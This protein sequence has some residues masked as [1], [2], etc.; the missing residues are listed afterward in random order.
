MKGYLD[1]V[2]NGQKSG[3]DSD[4]A[5]AVEQLSLKAYLKAKLSSQFQS[6]DERRE[7]RINRTSSPAIAGPPPWCPPP[8]AAAGTAARTAPSSPPAR[9]P[10]QT[11]PACYPQTSPGPAIPARSPRG[12][13]HDD[14]VHAAVT[15]SPIH[16]GVEVAPLHIL[17][18]RSGAVEHVVD[19]HVERA[20]PRPGPDVLDR[21]LLDKRD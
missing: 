9:S 18:P 17:R 11:P 16:V 15:Q 8:A 19:H 21:V 3:K 20:E 1:R 4:R 14:H 13:R 5:G 7:L 6:I 12:R 2:H 10:S